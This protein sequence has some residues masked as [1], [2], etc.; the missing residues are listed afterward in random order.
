MEQLAK[1]LRREQALLEFLLFKL[2]ETRLLL[3]AGEI[4][5]VPRS[6]REVERA[7]Q[8]T[9]GADLA[10]AAVVEGPTGAAAHGGSATL[11]ALADGA[12]EP[13]AGMLRDHHDA[14][15]GLVAEIELV[16]HHNAGLA[17]DGL[18]D[19]EGRLCQT[20]VGADALAAHR[21]TDDSSFSLA[22]DHSAYGSVLGSADRLRMPA[23]L[24]FLR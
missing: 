20:T 7:R 11:R 21:D 23:L 15:C 1:A 10:R 18:R 5:F 3:G 24:A 22:A 19:L 6:T 8:R 4:R 2:I 12:V 17:R 16:A 14:M 13:W 9:C